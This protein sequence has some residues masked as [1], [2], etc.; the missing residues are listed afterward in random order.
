MFVINNNGHV[1]FHSD[2]NQI[3]SMKVKQFFVEFLSKM[4]NLM[5]KGNFSK[6]K[7]MKL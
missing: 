5:L 7:K 2:Y 4:N 1:I 3:V 6:K